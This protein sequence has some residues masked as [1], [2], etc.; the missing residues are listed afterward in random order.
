MTTANLSWTAAS[1]SNFDY[2]QVY[3]GE[4]QTQVEGKISSFWSSLDDP[5]LASISTITTTITG[6]TFNTLYYFQAWAFDTF[7]NYLSSLV[8]SAVTNT[9]PV[10]S[11]LL[12]IP[13]TDG[14]G[15]AT[16]EFNIDDIDDNT[17]Q[18]KVEY[19]SDDGL[20]WHPATLDSEASAIYDSPSI[21]NEAAYQVTNITTDQGENT[22]SLGWL[23]QTDLPLTTSDTIKLR[24]TPN[25]GSIDGTTQ[26]STSF[27]LDNEAPTGLADFQSTQ[28]VG[29]RST[30]TWTEA[31]DTH[32]SHY[33]I[34]YGTNQTQVNN[35]TASEWDNDDDSDLVDSATTTTIITTIVPGNL[36]YAKLFA[37]DS[38]HNYLSSSTISFRS[39]SSTTRFF[40]QEEF[41]TPILDDGQSS[42]EPTPGGGGTSTPNNPPA[43]NPPAEEPQPENPLKPGDLVK[44]EISATVYLIGEDGKRHPFP[45]EAVY[46]SYYS[47]F[48][49]TAAAFDQV[50]IVP[51]EVLLQY[52]LGSPMTLKPG[53]LLKFLTSPKVYLVESPNV[54]RWI[55]NETIFKA[56]GYSFDLVRHFSDAFFGDYV[57]GDEIGE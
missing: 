53:G 7:G 43:E 19:S 48:I 51:P 17:C 35:R 41:P 39:H 2:Y 25:D 30:F 11:D 47:E 42:T 6:L 45:D 3:Y 55:V 26:T 56:L 36:Y 54:I 29:T 20:T 31:A 5:N 40:H 34:W 23:S 57:V 13:L 18:V 28:N 33:E 10:A 16:L 49:Y 22:L 46:F 38:Y 4:D 21:D 24:I 9:P 32:F 37:L 12:A 15:I 14:S 1:D 44:L 8:I 50:Q 27:A 52:P